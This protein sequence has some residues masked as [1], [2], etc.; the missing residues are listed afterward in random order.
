VSVRQIVSCYRFGLTPEEIADQYG[1]LTL[2]QV[3]A[4]LAYYHSS[5]TEI[6]ADLEHDDREFD[7]LAQMHNQQR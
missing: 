3:Y 1:H 4:A 6:D 7:R 5:P 2:A